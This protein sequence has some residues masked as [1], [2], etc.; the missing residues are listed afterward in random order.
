MTLNEHEQANCQRLGIGPELFALVE[1][2]A[3]SMVSIE[4]NYAREGSVLPD[5]RFHGQR[6]EVVQVAFVLRAAM[7]RSQPRPLFCPSCRSAKEPRLVLTDPDGGWHDCEDPWHYTSEET[8]D[9]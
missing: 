7:H 8:P 2:L 9:G 5:S 6:L 3:Q 4:A 1:E